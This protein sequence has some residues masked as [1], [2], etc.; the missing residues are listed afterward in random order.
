MDGGVC[1]NFWI[2]AVQV[3]FVGMNTNDC[4]ELGILY[5][6]A[7]VSGRPDSRFTGYLY[8]KRLIIRQRILSPSDVEEKHMGTMRQTRKEIVDFPRH[9]SQR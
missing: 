5:D 9:W 1:G 6:E 2:A 8:A 4:D 7:T 3:Y